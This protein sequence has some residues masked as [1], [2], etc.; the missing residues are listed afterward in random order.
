MKKLALTISL[1]ISTT[2]NAL[3]SDSWFRGGA[4]EPFLLQPLEIQTD[5]WATCAAAFDAAAMTQRAAGN[6][7]A[8]Q[9]FNDAGNGAELAVAMA[10]IMSFIQKNADDLESE[11]AVSEAYA[12]KFDHAWSVGKMKMENMPAAKSTWVMAQLEVADSPEDWLKQ[13][14]KTMEV[15][16][17][18]TDTQT[19]YVDL[20]RKMLSDGMFSTPE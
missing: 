19:M 3:A 4:D 8:A 15:C 14:A 5:S 16:T 9:A 2:A 1:V 20:W 13:L 11:G 17:A 6:N 10:E 7:N 12:A 18:N